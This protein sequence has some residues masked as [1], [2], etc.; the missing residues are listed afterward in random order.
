MPLNSSYI[1]VERAIPLFEEYLTYDALNT[2]C[3]SSFVSQ[4]P[5]LLTNSEVCT[6]MVLNSSCY[7]TLKQMGWWDTMLLHA[8]PGPDLT[9]DKQWLK[10]GH[11]LALA[12]ESKDP[13]RVMDLDDWT[14]FVVRH[15]PLYGFKA[16]SPDAFYHGRAFYVLATRLRPDIAH[17]VCTCPSLRMPLADLE[18]SIGSLWSPLQKAQYAWLLEKG[19]PDDTLSPGSKFIPD[20]LKNVLKDVAAWKALVPSEALIP[21]GI[22]YEMNNGIFNK[23]ILEMIQLTMSES[24]EVAE[25]LDYTV[26]L[27]T[28]I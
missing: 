15:G 6:H 23:T 14:D 11:A 26:I 12:Y 4:Y 2:Q 18:Q 24:I 13:A 9:M 16:G 5:W 8:Q 27:D 25:T 19:G 1:S 3:M 17:F 20:E 28:F 21:M 22:V 7:N 10:A